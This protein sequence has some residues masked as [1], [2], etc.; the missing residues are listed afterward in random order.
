MRT[1]GTF[2][3]KNAVWTSTAAA[4]A[5]ADL[6]LPLHP[7]ADKGQQYIPQIDSQSF[8]TY[9]QPLELGDLRSI[10]QL[11][12]T[13]TLRLGFNNILQTR[14][15][16][17]LARPDRARRRRRP[18]F[19]PQRPGA[20]FFRPAYAFL[21]HPAHWLEIYNDEIYRIGSFTMREFN[22]GI[23]LRDGSAWSLQLGESFLRRENDDYML[24]YRIR[25]NERFSALFMLEYGARQHRFNQQVIGLEE[26]S[27][28]PT[29]SNTS[30]PPATAPTR[31]AIS[32][33]RSMSRRFDFER[34]AP[35]TGRQTGRVSPVR[36]ERLA[37]PR[38]NAASSW[39]F[40]AS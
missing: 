31:R 1:S 30:S 36:R 19:P 22:T 25:L 15:P 20:G 29:G 10:D 39:T 34:R 17:R 37:R 35:K 33:S 4:P 11:A 23:I 24:N 38:V 40:F 28:T 26:T 3:Y 14:N 6:L 9:L 16:L 27:S 13:N 32:A 5:D 21:V 2:D 12:A 8:S 18:Q 7:E